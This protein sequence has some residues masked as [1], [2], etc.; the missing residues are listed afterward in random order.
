M[1]ALR[2]IV[3]TPYE[4]VALAIPSTLYPSEAT[5]FVQFL[6][7]QHHSLDPIDTD[8][9]QYVDVVSSSPWQLAHLTN[10]VLKEDRT[11]FDNGIRDGDVL[12]FERDMATEPV[13]HSAITDS[14]HSLDDKERLNELQQSSRRLSLITIGIW[15]L[16]LSLIH[17]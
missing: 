16:G 13:T 3:H 12:L 1:V 14:P 5:F 4:R 10:G 15:V 11:L 17:I 9:P 8:T 7:Q 2:V 6:L